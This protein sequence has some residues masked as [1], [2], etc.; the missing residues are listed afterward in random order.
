MMMKLAE[1]ATHKKSALE[2]MAAADF[3]QSELDRQNGLYDKLNLAASYLKPQGPNDALF[4]TEL[5]AEFAEFVADDPED[6]RDRDE[7]IQAVQRILKT[8]AEYHR[9]N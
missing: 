4:L 5:A 1:L 3:D 7:A 6:V 2:A 9:Q 8:L